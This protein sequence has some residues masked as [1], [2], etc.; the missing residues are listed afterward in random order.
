M[1]VSEDRRVEIVTYEAAN[2]AVTPAMVAFREAWTGTQ[3]K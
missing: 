1:L 3:V 2:M